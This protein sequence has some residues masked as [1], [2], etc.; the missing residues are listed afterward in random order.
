M[1][2]PKCLNLRMSRPVTP[3]AVWPRGPGGLTR[4][5]LAAQN[6]ELS[7]TPNTATV[8]AVYSTT[9]GRSLQYR[10]L[11]HTPDK[12]TWI[13]SLSNEFGR[14][15]Q[16]NDRVRGTNTIFFIPK[17]KI[18]AGRA[19]TYAS[20]VVSIRPEK[21]ETHRTRLTV[22]GNLINYPGEVS[23]DTADITTAK[24][25][26]NSVL[27]TPNAAFFGIDIKNFYLNTPMS[28]F[29]YVKLPISLISA[30]IQEWYNLQNKV[31]DKH[32][33]AQI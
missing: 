24:L 16:G 11:L 4:S 29:E 14:L 32:N 5:S 3:T 18:P 13:Q 8:N 15:A 6:K 2:V 30:D 33:R 23:T 7:C 26:F 27:S 22:G 25:L 10:Q 12:H 17:S 21:S 31:T 9:E 1:S 20:I 28:R 19:P